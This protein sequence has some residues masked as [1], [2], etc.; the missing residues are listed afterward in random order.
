M[1]KVINYNLFKRK[2][3]E[4]GISTRKIADLL[5]VSH[6]LVNS[7]EKQLVKSFKPEIE[8]KVMEILEIKKEDLYIQN[9]KENS[10]LKERGNFLKKLRKEHGVTIERLSEQIGKSK[11]TI[12]KWE[13]GKI[14]SIPA[15]DVESICD[16]FEI[17]E[18][19]FYTQAISNEKNEILTIVS[20]KTCEYTIND[21]IPYGRNKFK[22]K[23]ILEAGI[24]PEKELYIK[25]LVVNMALEG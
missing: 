1:K 14:G 17:S 4:K 11:S 18:I 15:R 22:V 9:E 6:N 19:E 3:E 10:T 20:D 13:K 8:K 7:W 25:L 2:R 23:K 5:G 24:T 16:F 12:C 21:I